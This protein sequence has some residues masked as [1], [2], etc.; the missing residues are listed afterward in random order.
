MLNR[1]K[2]YE[3]PR[4]G[5]TAGKTPEPPIFTCS[6]SVFPAH[7]TMTIETLA[8]SSSA[9]GLH[10]LGQQALTGTCT[11]TLHPPAGG[12]ADRKVPNWSAAV[13]MALPAS[14]GATAS[15]GANAL[16]RRS[17]TITF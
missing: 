6:Y 11:L 8:F 2:L 13:G 9:S 7:P 4:F 1:E 15:A 16:R 17:L 5:A 12:D 3:T 14:E 10:A